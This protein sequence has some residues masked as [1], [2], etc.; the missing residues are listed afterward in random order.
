VENRELTVDR[1]ENG[2]SSEPPLSSNHAR[3]PPSVGRTVPSVATVAA[4]SPAT[5]AGAPESPALTLGSIVSDLFP[6][7]VLPPWCMG[8]A[9]SGGWLRPHLRLLLWSA[10][11][12]RGRRCQMSGQA[13]CFP[14]FKRGLRYAAAPQ[15]CCVLLCGQGGEGEDATYARSAATCKW[16][17]RPCMDPWELPEF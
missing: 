16:P 9:P 2:E 1:S 8:A 10:V 17:G 4:G 12:A 3:A 13:T 6:L 11:E 14:I 7:E 5:G 15:A